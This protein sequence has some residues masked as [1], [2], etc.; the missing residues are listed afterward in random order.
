MVSPF[1]H[2]VPDL[3]LISYVLKWVLGRAECFVCWW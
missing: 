1:G 2:F 3:K